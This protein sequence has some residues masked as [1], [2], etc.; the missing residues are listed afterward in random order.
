M[1]S[2]FFNPL[3]IKAIDVFLEKRTRRLYVG[4]L[5]RQGENYL[6]DYD[7]SY[8][9]HPGVIPLGPEFPLTHQSFEQKQLYVSFADRLPDRENPA[10]QDYCRSENIS[11][12]TKDPIILLG[13]IGRRGPSSFI[14]EPAY[15]NEFGEQD[16][17]KFRDSLG[18]SL[19]DFSLLFG[20]SLSILQKINKGQSSGKDILKKIELYARFPELIH[21][22]IQK[23]GKFL[24][25]KKIDALIKRIS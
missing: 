10:Y 11:P 16:Y 21:Y 25:T 24:H 1:H 18:L 6:F 12:D 20:I 15:D 8:M 4:R 2:K 13:T 7:Q 17:Q 9:Y 5:K 19:E 3:N 14:F 22:E 23:N